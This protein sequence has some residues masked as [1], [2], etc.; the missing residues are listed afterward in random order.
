MADTIKLQAVAD[1]IEAKTKIFI[2]G[3]MDYSHIA[4]KLDAKEL[5]EANKYTKYAQTEGYYK[6]T[7]KVAS[8]LE[9]ES[10]FD[11]R[12]VLEFD[13][14]NKSELTLAAYVGSRIYPS[15]KEENKGNLYYSAISKGSEIRVYKEDA[16]GVLHRVNLNGNELGPNNVKLELNFFRTSK[17]CG[18][19]IN[20]IVIL[21]DEIKVYE[22]T[23]S[24]KGYDKEMG[25][26]IDLPKRVRTVDDT[27]PENDEPEEEPVATAEKKPVEVEDAPIGESAAANNDVFE[28]L[29]NKFKQ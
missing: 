9:D 7:I 4:T 14:S 17:G 20:S 8:G 23:A 12:S 19:G 21:D 16:Q 2:K 24:V 10:K 18:V 22:N 6:A 29:L 15:K 13:P 28:A 27:V 25:D 5:A 11:S 26:S 1:Q 3:V